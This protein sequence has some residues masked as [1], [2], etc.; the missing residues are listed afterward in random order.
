MDVLFGSTQGSGHEYGR[1][2]FCPGLRNSDSDVCRIHPKEF[3]W[4]VAM[5]PLL[6]HRRCMGPCLA[7][8]SFMMGYGLVGLPHGGARTVGPLDLLGRT[9]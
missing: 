1:L 6:L 8:C 2:W 4:A 9:T 5:G 3:L 7:W